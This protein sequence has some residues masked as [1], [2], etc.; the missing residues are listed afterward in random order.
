MASDNV[1]MF[2]ADYKECVEHAVVQ[3]IE[4]SERAIIMI[5]I[6]QYYIQDWTFCSTLLILTFSKMP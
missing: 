3:R 1:K 4:F 2:T 5:V 6:K